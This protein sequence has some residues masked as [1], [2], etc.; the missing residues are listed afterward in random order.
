MILSVG[1]ESIFLSK[2]LIS[3]ISVDENDVIANNSVY[4]LKVYFTDTRKEY[5]A[6]KVP[7]Q[8]P[9]ENIGNVR[10]SVIDVETEKTLIDY[11]DNATLMFY[12]GEKYVFD[13]FVPKMFKNMRINFKFKYKDI[14]TD[15]DKFIF[16]EKYSIRIV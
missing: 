11:D 2:N 4:S 8:L 3:V 9:S 1:L 7:F 6:V 10:Y 16:N 14:I 13:L 5:D 12:D 15:T